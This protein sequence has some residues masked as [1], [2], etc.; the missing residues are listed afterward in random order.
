MSDIITGQGRA[1]RVELFAILVIVVVLHFL[2]VVPL[3]IPLLDE[4]LSSAQGPEPD[5]VAILLVMATTGISIWLIFACSAR[6]LTDLGH[7]KGFVVLLAIPAVNILFF[8]Y[9]LAAP[10]SAVSGAFDRRGPAALSGQQQRAV[11]KLGTIDLRDQETKHLNPDG[12]FN[13]DGIFDYSQTR[14]R[15]P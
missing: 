13:P 10:G 11:K 4:A 14:Q 12:T 5:P 3:G 2:V 8:L 1:G 6:R 7:S 15:K 9:L